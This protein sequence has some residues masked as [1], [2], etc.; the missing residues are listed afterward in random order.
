[1]G[2]TSSKADPDLWMRAALK[3]NRDKI[4]NY[5]ISYVDDLVFQG[6]DPKGFMDA[7][8]QRFTLKPGSIKKPDTYLG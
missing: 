6:F 2:F 3:A 8:G 7:L 5:V 1:M 4:Y